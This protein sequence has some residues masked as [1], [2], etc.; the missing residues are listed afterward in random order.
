MKTLIIA[1]WKENPTTQ[2]EAKELFELVKKGVKGIKHAE[3]V[4]CPP[5]VYLPLFSGI[6]LGAQNVSYEEKGAFTGEVSSLML[7]D[8]KVTYV[9]VGH[10]EARKYLNETDEIVNKKIKEVLAVKLKPILCIGEN[11]GEDKQ[12]VLERQLMD[13]LREVINHKSEILNVVIAY[14]PIW[15]VGTGNNCSVEETKKSVLLIREIIA[16]LYNESVAKNVMV[17][18]GGSVNSQ[19]SGEY[20][21]NGGVDGL[22]V[23][24]ASLN[25][26]EFI[27]IVKS[28]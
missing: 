21:K 23:G 27:N 5:F 22:L 18:Y 14:E 9:I 24:R 3:V 11:T 26:E 13:G 16:K 19:N 17:L 7:K 8:L 28:V 1:N 10:S 12:Q 15:A 2:Q 25:A 6:T 20:I 4:I